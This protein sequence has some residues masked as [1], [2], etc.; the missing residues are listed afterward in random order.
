MSRS[1]VCHC[2]CHCR[3][4][5]RCPAVQVSSPILLRLPRSLAVRE[6]DA[7]GMQAAV[8]Y[9]RQRCTPAPL[10]SAAKNRC[11]GLAGG[12][13]FARAREAF[14]FSHGERHLRRLRSGLPGCFSTEHRGRISSR[15]S[16]PAA[17]DTRHP[18]SSIRSHLYLL[19]LLPQHRKPPPQARRARIQDP[20]P[21]YVS[22]TRQIQPPAETGAAT[23]HRA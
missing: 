19:F 18:F 1:H 5:N 8:R 9:A 10:A 6:T 7:E 17:A 11:P 23:A 15:I 3:G 20:P 16:D 2:H 13:S 22:L 21:S 14:Y 12:P 4:G